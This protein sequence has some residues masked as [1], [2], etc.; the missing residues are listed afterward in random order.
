MSQDISNPSISLECIKPKDTISFVVRRSQAHLVSGVI[1][2]AKLPQSRHQG[3]KLNLQTSPRLIEPR[4]VLFQL[5]RPDEQSK[6]GDI[7]QGLPKIEQLFEARGV[8]KEISSQNNLKSLSVSKLYS[9][10]GGRAHRI[11]DFVS[12]GNPAPRRSEGELVQQPGPPET[13]VKKNGG[14]S[15]D[16]SKTNLN[17][18]TGDPQSNTIKKSTPNFSSLSEV[19][20]NL[21]RTLVS[22]IQSVY[23]SQGVEISDKHIEIIVRQMTSKVRI[24]EKGKTPFFPDDIVDLDSLKIVENRL[25]TFNPAPISTQEKEP[26]TRYPAPVTPSLVRGS[27]AKLPNPPHYNIKRVLGGLIAPRGVRDS[28]TRPHSLLKNSRGQ[29][30]VEG[31]PPP[32]WGAPEVGGA[33]HPVVGGTPP[34]GG[35]PPTPP[36][37]PIGG[38]GGKGGR[39]VESQTNHTQLHTVP[40]YQPIILGITKIAFMTDSFISAA[41]FQETKRVLMNSALQNRIDSLCGL[42]ENVILGRL[43]PAG[44]G[45]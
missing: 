11:R 36:D 3:S 43:I 33:P 26:R 38:Q 5:L 21:Q 6:T 39:V 15:G 41:S 37:P 7:V 18:A 42:K 16:K 2:E 34:P 17:W 4:E 29:D 20:L 27:G 25:K 40:P 12:R 13:L 14:L 31:P 1:E 22:E 28:F 35:A 24:L 9:R 44:T 10:D 19:R 32:A 23:Q 45:R 30:G 8:T